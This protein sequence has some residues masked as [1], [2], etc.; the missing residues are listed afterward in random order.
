MVVRRLLLLPLLVVLSL[1]LSATPTITGELEYSH[2]L[3]YYASG[4]VADLQTGALGIT[5]AS[6]RVTNVR[7]E[8][9][10]RLPP[11][12]DGTAW[13]HYLS[14]A[15][16]KVRFPSLRLT[17]GKAPLSWGDGLLFNA[18]DLPHRRWDR[19][20]DSQPPTRWMTTLTYPIG[21]FNSLEALLVPSHDGDATHLGLGGRLYMSLGSLKVEAG[22][23]SLAEPARLHTPYIG[24]QG[25]LG[26]NW[27][28]VSSMDFN[29]TKIEELRVSAGMLHPIWLSGGGG[30]TLRLEGLY[31]TGDVLS[32]GF[33][34]SWAPSSD[35]TWSLQTLLVPTTEVMRTTISSS[36]RALQGVT[37]SSYLTLSLTG[38]S[39]STLSLSAAASWIF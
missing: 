34:G 19:S 30:I 10:L 36:W 1:S 22:Y 21:A 3:L 24:V 14:R 31:T 37:L 6:S 20:A 25:H 4:S 39:F 12:S 27:W 9:S 17:V 26:V 18:G 35:L 23:M 38:W 5:L 2:S 11:Q 7:G 29:I 13:E 8:L 28:A 16:V 33:D 15:Y 32:L